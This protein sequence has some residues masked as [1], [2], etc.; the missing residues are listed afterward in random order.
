M[1]GIIV[2]IEAHLQAASLKRLEQDFAKTAATLGTGLS[3]SATPAAISFSKQ[4]TTTLAARLKEESQVLGAQLSAGVLSPAQYQQAAQRL[5]REIAKDLQ[6]GVQSGNR[7]ELFGGPAG[8]ALRNQLQAVTVAATQTAPAAQKVATAVTQVGIAGVASST[9]LN[10]VRN[11]LVQVALSATGSA[12]PLGRFASS[13]LLFGGGGSVVL[14]IAAGAAVIGTAWSLITRKAHEASEETKKWIEA[15]REANRVARP[16]F[17]QLGEE[18]A[19][20]EKE[21]QGFQDK[22]ARATAQRTLIVRKPGESGPMKE[23]IDQIAI[24]EE[25]L[26]GLRKQV[27][28]LNSSTVTFKGQT[29]TTTVEST[30]LRN[31]TEE[32]EEAERTREK[33]ARAATKRLDE[34]K[35]H[36]EEL[37]KAQ[38]ELTG[39][40]NAFWDDIEAKANLAGPMVVAR[41]KEMQKAAKEAFTEK[42]QWNFDKV[43]QNLDV[44]EKGLDEIGEGNKVFSKFKQDVEDTRTPT[45]KLRDSIHGITGAL[46][47]LIQRNG[48]ALL[49][50][51]ATRSIGSVLNLVDAIGDLRDSLGNITAAGAIGLGSAALGVIGSLTGESAASKALREAIE[52]NVLALRDLNENLDELNVSMTGARFGATQTGLRSV[53]ARGAQGE[54]RDIGVNFGGDMFSDLAELDSALRKAG[55]SLKD[56]RALAE[57]LGI[58]LEGN[59]IAQFVQLQEALDKVD[60]TKFTDTFE[61]QVELDE[62][63]R[64]LEGGETSAQARLAALTK[65]LQDPE[66]GSSALGNVLGMGTDFS[67]KEGLEKVKKRLQELLEDFPNLAAEQLGGLTRDQ[68]LDAL[69]QAGDLVNEGL[70]DLAQAAIDASTTAREGLLTEEDAQVRAA[71]EAERAQAIVEAIAAGTAAGGPAAVL[72]GQIA[73]AEELRKQLEGGELGVESP[74]AQEQRRIIDELL[75]QLGSIAPSGKTDGKVSAG[76]TVQ[77]TITETSAGRLIG[78]L[79][80][81]TGLLTQIRDILAGGKPIVTGT[82][83]GIAATVPVTEVHVYIGE[84]DIT[85]RVGVRM[86]R[87]FQHAAA[88]N[89]NNTMS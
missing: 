14:G 29:I 72:A 50:E 38:L 30:G 67:T 19:R 66:T 49:G 60:L 43:Q 57:E 28:G 74:L 24:A 48:I 70:A 10:R 2:E 81:Q 42:V 51:D 54:G 5:G 32:A 34:L 41:L 88:M 31:V 21:L 9:G 75:G 62:R 18:I 77:R 13:L 20:A 11:G 65:Q 16:E 45:E 71:H 84:E 23:L 40:F 36:T 4:L 52:R 25:R 53:L 76:F 56:V 79:T 27:D 89:G 80:S 3:A 47:N 22:L 86:Y 12:G 73:A 64:R 61:G 63:R 58:S 39:A 17:V 78:E 55:T 6:K 7:L 37:R 35:R 69:N 82:G 8:L 83:G 87:N 46:D 1:A 33:N 26:A 85:D 59:T 15:A 44:I 68:F